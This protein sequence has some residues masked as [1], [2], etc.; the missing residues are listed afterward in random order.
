M[1][2][3][4]HLVRRFV[5]SLGSAEPSA[6]DLELV[7]VHLAPGELRCWQ[8]MPVQDR[9]HSVLVARR[10]LERRPTAE[11]AEVAGALLHDV[12]KQQARLGTFMRVLATVVGPRTAR[13]RMYHDH[14][15]L[16]AAMLA[17]AGSD[18]ATV[19][20]VLGSGPA[21]AALRDADEV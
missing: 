6:A 9:R 3:A 16:G 14:E 5:G 15:T 11:R 12:G 17:Q 7:R 8:A 20:L 21:A 19:E 4:M 10:F 13:F 18:P 2:A 1:S